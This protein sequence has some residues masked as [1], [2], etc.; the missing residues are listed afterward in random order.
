[1]TTLQM[2]KLGAV[3]EIRKTGAETGGEVIEGSMRLVLGG[4]E[5]VLRPGDVMTV[6]VGA[7]HRQLPGDGPGRVRVQLRPAGDTEAFLHRMAE[8]DLN[9][10]G[11]PR[12]VAAAA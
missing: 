11:Y 12:P 4:R 9:R 3:I 6:P 7:S 8:M 2:P 5:H 10:F 1:M